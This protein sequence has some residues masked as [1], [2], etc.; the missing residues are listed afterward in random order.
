MALVEPF[1]RTPEGEQASVYTIEN[2]ALRVRITDYGGRMVSIEA[3]DRTGRR[4]HVLLGFSE[5]AEYARNGGSFGALLGRNA[6]RIA[7]AELPL[8]GQ[9]Y[10]LIPNDRGNTLHGGPNGFGM[11]MWQVV[12]ADASEVVLSHV[13]PGGDQGFPGDL[14]VQARYRLAG[15]TLS[16]ML[17]AHTT[18]PTEAS[19]SAHPYFNL[20]GPER[21]D[22]LGHELTIQADDFLPTDASQLPTGEIRRVDGGLFDFRQPA[23]IGARIRRSDPQLLRAQG[24]DHFFVLDRP[25][26]TEARFAARLR[27]PQSGRILEVHTTQP[28]TQL[29]T[30]NQLRGL[31][32]GHGNIIYRQSAGLAFEP[33]GFLDASHHANFPSTT[34]RPGETYRQVIEYRFGTD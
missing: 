34:L 29:Y 27:D 15:N 30:G 23:T 11:V 32:A 14:S 28:G 9:I 22:I 10:R 8:D 2:E 5:V 31:F 19:L 24:F 1:G 20:G 16:L 13:S 17:T 18:K 21:G 7:R 33:Q 6:N 3:P 4:D 26:G 12:S 25:P